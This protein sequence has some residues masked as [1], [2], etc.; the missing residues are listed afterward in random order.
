MLKRL[1]LYGALSAKVQRPDYRLLIYKGG[2]V[3]I[4][5]SESGYTLRYESPEGF[6]HLVAAWARN[7]GAEEQMQEYLLTLAD[8]SRWKS[9]R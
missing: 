8:E 5:A 3:T 9:V 4:T 1:D 2:R 6:G 7:K